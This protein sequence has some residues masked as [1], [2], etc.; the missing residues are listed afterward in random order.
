MKVPNIGEIE[1][2]RLDWPF[3]II[4]NKEKYH[5]EYVATLKSYQDDILTICLGISSNAS[6]MIRLEEF[7]LGAIPDKVD[8]IVGSKTLSYPCTLRIP[9]QR[10]L[11]P[12]R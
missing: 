11:H 1:S 4:D 3:L 7:T 12:T 8:V 2:I 10:G 6:T 9:P 5:A